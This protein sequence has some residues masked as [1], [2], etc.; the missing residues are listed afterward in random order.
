MMGFADARGF[1]DYMV[2]V[3]EHG[4]GL[5][6]DEW[7]TGLNDGPFPYWTNPDHAYQAGELLI[8]ALQYACP[9][10]DLGLRY[11]TPIL[12]HEGGCEPLSLP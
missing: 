7:R 5:M 12:L 10:E 4:I 11:E 3:F 6:G 9:E 1:S 2:P 8:C